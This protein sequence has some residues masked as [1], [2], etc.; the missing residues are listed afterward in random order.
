MTINENKFTDLQERGLCF[1]PEKSCL[2]FLSQLGISYEGLTHDEA[3]TIEKC[4]KIE[5]SLG[6]KIAKNLFLCNSQKTSFY[7]LI[8]P[9][10]KIFK[11]KYLSKQINSSRLS[12]ADAENMKKY[13]GLRP[14]SVSILGLKNDMEKKVKLIIDR[15]LLSL[16]YVGFHPCINTSTLKLRLTDVLNKFLPAVNSEP[17]TVDLPGE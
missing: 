12:F 17:I 10:D 15:D 7:L 5:E 3:D 6:A 2:S 9:G 11:T 4:E 13:L 1:E 8:M 16:E 14:G